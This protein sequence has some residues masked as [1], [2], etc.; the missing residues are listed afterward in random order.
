VAVLG[1]S[2]S[3]T[4]MRGA[5][6][7]QRSLRDHNLGLALRQVA[8]SAEP[9][10]RADIAA[11]TGLTRSTAST[12]V[13]ALLVGGLVLELEPGART[14]AG[15]PATGLVL[16][17][18]GAA[19]IGLEVNV[20]Y[21]AVCVVDLAGRVRD[22]SVVL[23]DQRGRQPDSVLGDLADLAAAA[24]EKA[25]RGGLPLMGATV[26]VP[27]LVEAPDGPLRLAPNLGWQD[28]DV[29]AAFRGDARLADLPLT[30]D[31]EANLAALG[32]LYTGGAGGAQSFVQLS[33]EIGVGAGIVL[34]GRLFRG[35]H[36]W[37]GEIG[38][39]AMRPDGPPC[40][41]GSRGCLEQLAGQEA[42]LRAAGLRTPAGTTMA[43]QPGVEQIV[44]LA[45]S[46]R[47]D[48]LR[49]LDQAGTALG[50]AVAG[51]VNLVDVDTVVLGGLY[52]ALAPWVAPHVEREIAARV[53]AHRWSPVTVTVSGLGGD[54]AI[55]GGAGA[56][57]QQVLDHPGSRF[58]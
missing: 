5:P 16:A 40:G 24:R 56:V 37:G 7:R 53:L 42:I 22:R 6:A 33:G 41:C 52:A 43:G 15:R 23:A 18:D 2:V 29:L 46:G 8:G 25:E 51:V 30:I 9:V 34:D 4:G 50:V 38:H 17:P 1:E 48:M 28:I 27:G 54:A 44:E 10:S 55:R 3:P 13:D 57:L 11:A 20:D 26:A 45:E 58:A 36:G 32:E 49:A 39:L 14:G 47:A 21:L 31:N 19:G 12:L 35:T